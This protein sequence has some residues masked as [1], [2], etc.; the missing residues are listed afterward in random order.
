MPEV[1]AWAQVKNTSIKFYAV[2]LFFLFAFFLSISLIS[3][4]IWNFNRVV[5]IL[6][7]SFI[8]IYNFHH[9][10]WQFHGLSRLY[11]QPPIMLSSLVIEKIIARWL[12]IAIACRL[13]IKT[14]LPIEFKHQFAL[15]VSCLNDVIF[16]ISFLLALSLIYLAY[17]QYLIKKTNKLFYV[18][19]F[20]ILI[21][22]PDLSFAIVA[23]AAIHGIEYFFVFMQMSANSQ[24]SVRFRKKFYISTSLIAMIGL[25]S[26]LLRQKFS[27]PFIGNPS[28]NL[29]LSWQLFA[30]FSIACSLMHFYLDGKLFAFKDKKT[31]QFILPLLSLKKS[32]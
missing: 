6:A 27:I 22:I 14:A 31:N 13:L 10:I 15:Q 30:S 9:A 32:N 12:F 29:S 16:V 23:M 17:K 3:D 1:R 18:P 4:R 8:I 11:Q 5:F 2:K 19:R 21:F 25:I 20:L 7:Y 24:T 28:Q 26:L